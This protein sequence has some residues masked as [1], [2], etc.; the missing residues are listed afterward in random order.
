MKRFIIAACIVVLMFYAVYT[1]FYRFGIYI[2]LN[3]DAPVTTFMTTDEDTIYMTKDGKTEPFEIR[4]VNL[5]VGIP[6]EW[7]TDYAI[8]KETYLRWF[9]WIQE[10]G[11]NTIRV[12]TI[13][14]NDFYDAFYEYNQGR[15]DPLYLIHGVWVNDYV[16]NSHRDA[17]DDDF[18]QTLLDD[19]RTVVDILHGKKNLNLG[20]G[21]GSGSYRSD[22]SPWVIGYILGVEWEDVT[23]VY[24]DHKYPDRNQY[25]GTYMYTTPEASPFE[26]MLC[27]VGD[28]II[29]Y[30]TNRYKQQRLVAFSNWPTTDPFDYPEDV[31]L[32]FMKCAK[33]DVEHIATTDQ[34]LS[35]HFASY[36]VYPYYP[37]YLNYVPGKE[38]FPVT[39]D[40]EINTYLEYLT[41]LT[42][43]HTIPVVISEYG[44]ST[45][46]GMAQRDYNTGRNQGHMSEDE[47][48][49]ALIECYE[50]IMAAGCAGSCVFTWQ[51]EWFKRTWNTMHAVDLLNTPYWS[52]YQTNEQ[53]FGLLSFDPGEE[54][55]VCYVDGDISEWEE[56]DL[57]AEY[58]VMSLSMKY[59]EKFI[60]FLIKKEDFSSE[61]DVLYLPVDITPKT[62]STYCENYDISFSQASDF[63]IVIDGKENSRV[64]VQERYE[65]M[66]A[67][68]LHETED[69]DA[70]LNPVDPDTPVFKPIMLMLQTATPLLSGDWESTAEVYETGVLTYGNAN[71]E[72]EDFNSL[73]DFIFAGNYIELKLP[74]QLLNF[75]N[76]SEMMVH[77][78]Y[79]EKYG[80]EFI[81]IEEMYVGISSQ[82]Y[83]EYRIPM[84]A[85]ALEGWGKEVTYHERLKQSYYELKEYW[86]AH[87]T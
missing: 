20:Y 24:T 22:V 43:H 6:G 67:M 83:E 77:D 50:D 14:H 16:Q 29:E 49:E 62:G 72:A 42:A 52:D 73:A 35:G 23:V 28:K 57:V 21:I 18:R 61:E 11:A 81:Q 86:T 85:F 2:D 3:P 46:R 65:V 55:S 54:E 79:Y 58:K 87:P 44:V 32:Y 59:D 5:G 82:E 13:L 70:H 53:Y 64:L 74:W 45:G 26:A 68:F 27:E 80:V 25:I 31:T 66:R 39:E 60:Y 30:E 41:R 9:A 76:P 78:D 33:V 38:T 84:E 4:G 63:L 17:Y 15:E 36:H 75:G 10:M 51:D 7:A 1:A 69:E 8:D 48:G 40:G 47:Q 34:F 12:Y 19:C 37:D 56:S 71:P